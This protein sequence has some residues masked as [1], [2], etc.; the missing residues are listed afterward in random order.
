MIIRS[1][2]RK[3]T[4]DLELHFDLCE[5]ESHSTF[6]AKAAFFYAQQKTASV[7]QIENV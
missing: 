1:K 3:V 4:I 2:K 6:V 7:L 5:N